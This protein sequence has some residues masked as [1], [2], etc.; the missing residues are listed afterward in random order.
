M[1]NEVPYST[2]LKMQ[3]IKCLKHHRVVDRV[4][5]DDEFWKF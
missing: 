2:F 4:Y 1:N 3:T 5:L